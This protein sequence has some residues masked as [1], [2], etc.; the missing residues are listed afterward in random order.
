MSMTPSQYVKKKGLNSLAQMCD[1]SGKAHSTLSDWYRNDRKTFDIMLI[2]CIAF[3]KSPEARWLAPELLI[4]TGFKGKVTVKL[5][6]DNQFTI[7]VCRD[8]LYIHTTRGRNIPIE[9]IAAVMVL[10]SD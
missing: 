10:E 3:V 5:E 6:R 1:I 7:A 4:E 2:G 8:G 9:E